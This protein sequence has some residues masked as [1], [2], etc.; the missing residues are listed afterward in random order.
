VIQIQGDIAIGSIS[1]LPIGRR[2]ERF[3]LIYAI[4]AKLKI[5]ITRV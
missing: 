3:K 2:S 4:L 1:R 5:C